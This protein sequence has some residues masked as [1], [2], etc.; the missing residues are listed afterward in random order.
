MSKENRKNIPKAKKEQRNQHD[1]S[2][3]NVLEDEPEGKHFNEGVTAR[4]QK[5]DH[6]FQSDPDAYLGAEEVDDDESMSSV[7]G[8]STTGITAPE[9]REE[10]EEEEEETLEEIKKD[11]TG[12]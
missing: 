10:L 1:T 8:R 2:A 6:N 3:D 4:R 11:M 12:G 9:I 7:S 5:G